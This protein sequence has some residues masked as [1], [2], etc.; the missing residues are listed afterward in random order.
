MLCEIS[1]KTA[2][3]R[4]AASGELPAFLQTENPQ[5][6]HRVLH[7]RRAAAYRQIADVVIEAEEKTS[8]EIAMEILKLNIFKNGAF[9]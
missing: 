1:V 4:I 8:D 5:E 3:S 2:W 9:L 7:E 6:S